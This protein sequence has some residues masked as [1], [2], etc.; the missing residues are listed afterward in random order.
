MKLIPPRRR[1]RLWLTTWRFKSNWLWRRTSNSRRQTRKSR[2]WLPKL[3]K[4][5]NRPRSTTL[6]SSIGITRVSNFSSNIFSSILLQWTW[7]TWTSRQS[8]KKWRLTR[9]PRLLLL[10]PKRMLQGGMV[11][12]LRTLL[13]MQLVATRL[14]FNYFPVYQNFLLPFPSLFFIFI[15]IF[16]F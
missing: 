14:P 5:F 16:L 15:F 7:R 6:C 10:F 9:L 2:L 3:F 8:I 11:V 12:N 1:L 4:P 13:L